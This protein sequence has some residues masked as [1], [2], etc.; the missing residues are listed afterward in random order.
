[1]GLSAPRYEDALPSTSATCTS[2]TQRDRDCPRVDRF[3]Q[4]ALRQGHRRGLQLPRQ[5]VRVSGW[6]NS[7]RRD[8][9]PPDWFKIRARVLR[10]DGHTCT[11]RDANGIRCADLATDVDHIRPGDDHSMENLR[12]LCSWHHG[13][14]SGAEGAAAKAANW[15]R[16]NQKF[17]R[18]EDHP[19][20]L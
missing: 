2:S 12:A 4:L 3:E 7:N 9:L 6:Q 17:R 14:K 18:S 1:M 8:R 20:L 19:G 10:R 5:E 11:H 13:Q 15:R 16:Q